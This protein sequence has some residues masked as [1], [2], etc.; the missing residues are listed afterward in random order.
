[1]LMPDSNHSWI[2]AEILGVLLAAVSPIVVFVALWNVGHDWLVSTFGSPGL[3][4]YGVGAGLVLG[5][6][7]LSL[8]AIQKVLR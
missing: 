3:F 5:C 8:A 7:Y 1:M 6:Y 2:R 4:N